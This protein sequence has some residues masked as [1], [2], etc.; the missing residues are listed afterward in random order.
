MNVSISEMIMI[1]IAVLIVVI[2]IVI[3]FRYVNMSKQQNSQATESL[4]GIMSSYDDPEKQAYDGTTVLGTEVK[5]LAKKAI[6]NTAGWEDIHIVVETKSGTLHDFSKSGTAISDVTLPTST[7]STP[8]NDTN[9]VEKLN[10][11]ASFN[12][13]LV[14]D[15]DGI[16]RALYFKQK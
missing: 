1:A 2:V 8:S 3:G 10:S 16:I 5:E 4:S 9:I 7:T 12:C 14:R 13:T 15:T 6:N 11:G